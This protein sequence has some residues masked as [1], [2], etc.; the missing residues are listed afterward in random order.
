MDRVVITGIGCITALGAN[1]EELWKALLRGQSAVSPVIGFDSSDLERYV[2]CQIREIQNDST[3][4]VETTHGRATRLGLIAARQALV[5]ANLNDTTG[6]NMG[7][8]VGTTMGEAHSGLAVSGVSLKID[9][10]ELPERNVQQLRCDSISIGIATS[11]GI[12]GELLTI[13]TACAAGNYAVGYGFEQIRS[14]AAEYMVVGGS[15]AFSRIAFTGFCR[16]QALSPDLCRPFDRNRKG[17]LVGEGSG[18]L[19]LESLSHARKRNAR[20]YAEVVGYGI[21]CDGHHIT[22][23]HPEGKGAALAI[24]RAMESARIGINDV[25]YINAHGTGTQ[26][27]DRIETAAIKRVFGS[28]AYNV[29]VSSIKAL[30]GHAMGAASAIEAVVCS[31]ALSQKV[32]PPTW[33]YQEKDPECDLDYVPN[34]PRKE[35][36]LRT[37][38]SNSFA[39]GGNNACIVLREI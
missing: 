39:F 2:A 19:V 9:G 17:L 8:C 30:I 28:D 24:L 34:E 36:K 23:P 14:E 33:N 26:A 11:L 12:E 27:N 25:D 20:C 13:P 37:I 7:L 5:D 1:K 35:S 4:S 6:L 18:F 22:S 32:I 16:L 29:P 31:L 3:L 21:S 15:D 10:R 38:I